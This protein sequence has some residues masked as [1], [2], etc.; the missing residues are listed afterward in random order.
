VACCNAHGQVTVNGVALHERSYLYPGAAP[1]EIHFSITVPKGRLW[2]MGDNRQVSDDSRLHTSD[3]GRG[4]IPENKVIGR[5]FMIVWPPSRWRVLQIPSTFGQPG[6]APAASAALRAVAA[7]G[8]AAPYLP[9]TGGFA[10]ALPLTWLQWRVRRRRGRRRPGGLSESGD[11][12]G[13]GRRAQ[14]RR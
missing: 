9:V 13:R 12:S 14:G 10:V 7:A 4:T 2:V 1:S 5:A 11:R 8:P 6:I 3:P